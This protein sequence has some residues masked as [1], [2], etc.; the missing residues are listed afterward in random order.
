MQARRIIST[1]CLLE[2]YTDGAPFL[3]LRLN[4]PEKGGGFS[5]HFFKN[6]VEV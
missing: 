2:I 1:Y 6:T 4:I 3:L 5:Y